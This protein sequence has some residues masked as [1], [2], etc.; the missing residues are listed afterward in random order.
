MT[1]GLTVSGNAQTVCDKLRDVFLETI[2]RALGVA[3]N[4]D[5]QYINLLLK[6]VLHKSISV[7]KI[8]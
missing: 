8:S 4:P 1:P 2:K 7:G 3:L 5:V 6:A